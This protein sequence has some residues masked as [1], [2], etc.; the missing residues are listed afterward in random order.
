M[1]HSKHQE[2]H[3]EETVRGRR[4]VDDEFFSV[5]QWLVSSSR[6]V[7]CFSSYSRVMEVLSQW[8]ISS[9]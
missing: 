8:S 4:Q 1:A 9:T 6:D 3:G 7:G 5:W 2:K